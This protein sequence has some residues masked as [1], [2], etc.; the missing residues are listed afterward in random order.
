MPAT[1]FRT[2]IGVGEIELD[3]YGGDFS[4]AISLG[5]PHEDGT[6]V[7]YTAEAVKVRSGKTGGIREIFNNTAYD[8]AIEC[9]LLDAKARN[10]ALSFGKP[11][12]S[13]TDN[14]G[15]SP[16]NETFD[17]GAYTFPDYLA[18]RLKNPTPN[19]ATLFDTFTFYRVM[20]IPRFNQVMS[21]GQARFI[22]VR[23]ECTEDP[24]NGNKYGQ[25][26]MEYDGGD[27]P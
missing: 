15:G 25:V 10:M 24:S 7:E 1:N 4:A 26:K 18:L 12:S 27:L 3:S 5:H 8:L 11:T 20:V 21:I 14:S 6:T 9:M 2:R 16:A 19:D 13:V 22:P 23:F 17:I